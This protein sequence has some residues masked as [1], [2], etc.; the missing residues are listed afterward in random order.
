MEFW[1]VEIPE[2]EKPY[3]VLI[4]GHIE[5]P[6]QYVEHAQNFIFGFNFG[7]TQHGARELEAQE[8]DLKNDYKNR[9]FRFSWKYKNYLRKN[10]LLDKWLKSRAVLLTLKKGNDTKN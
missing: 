1:G 3:L 7:R 10:G 2:L 9:G 4:G 8:F 5:V 6:F